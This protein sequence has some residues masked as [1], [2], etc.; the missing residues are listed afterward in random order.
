[1]SGSAG[2]KISQL[3]TATSL[4]ATDLLPIVQGT[5]NRLTRAVTLGDLRTAIFANNT[6]PL[7]VVNNT[8]SAND[9]T[10]GYGFDIGGARRANIITGRVGATAEANVT[11]SVM[12]GNTQ[13]QEV[14]RLTP[15]QVQALRP[16]TVSAGSDAVNLSLSGRSSD[17]TSCLRFMQSNQATE[18]GAFV[19]TPGS[20]TL[21]VGEVPSFVVTPSG[22]SIT[23]IG[24][25][26]ATLAAGGK[27]WLVKAAGST[28]LGNV[29]IDTTAQ[30]LRIYEDGGTSRGA[31]LDLAE[32]AAGQGSQI[33]LRS[34]A[35]TKLALNGGTLTGAL[36]LNANPTANLHAATKQYVDNTLASDGSGR[37]AK[38]G[39]TMTGPLVLVTPTSGDHAARRD[40]V[41]WERL[42][43]TVPT[44]GATWIEF[45]LDLTF[46]S[47]D[48]DLSGCRNITSGMETFLVYQVSSD[49]GATWAQGATD[50]VS[51]YG[52]TTPIVAG[53]GRLSSP[54]Q[55]ASINSGFSLL[56]V[57]VSRAN[58]GLATATQQMLLHGTPV[59]NW[60]NG[61]VGSVT[62]FANPNRI[63]FAW[64][65]DTWEAA[66][67]IRMSG[68]RA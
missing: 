48:F 37:V 56:A 36:T 38:A 44:A 26:N 4:G 59:N 30:R 29:S 39:D 18:V 8:S 12:A 16:L 32:C 51:V 2:T 11:F 60:F 17:N 21:R 24:Y 3:P 7:I 19:A 64:A 53:I 62:G 35:D 1:M 9:T 54:L 61:I 28:L 52:N 40:T 58:V 46:V 15:I 13:L 45:P 22:A 43:S 66:G 34:Y 49:G 50:Y 42:S 5:T 27:H 6:A 47:W 65:N 25:G 67:R 20:V 57:R 63:R 31:F 55:R 14:L 10:A 33:A 23:S 41:A 68:F